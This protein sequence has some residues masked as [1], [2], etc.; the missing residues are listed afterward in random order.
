L[1]GIPK[2]FDFTCLKEN[3][4]IKE[5]KEVVKIK[6]LGSDH[7]C[8]DDQKNCEEKQM[9][10]EQNKIL[11]KEEKEDDHKI[12]EYIKANPLKGV[13]SIKE[14]CK[15][16]K[17]KATHH[18]LKS[19]LYNIRQELFPLDKEM[20]LSK[21]FCLTKGNFGGGINFCRFKGYVRDSK[22]NNNEVMIFSS[23]CLL[24]I[25]KND[26]W[27]VDAT[28]KVAAKGY[29]QL[30]IVIVYHAISRCYLPA[31]FILM[32]H[33][34]N[35]SYKLA[36]SALS[37]ICQEL[38]LNIQPSYIMCDFETAMRN[39]IRSYFPNAKIAG[40]YFH[41]VKALWHYV[42]SNGLTTKEKLHDTIKLVTFLKVLAHIEI[43]DRKELFEE[44][45][46]GFLKAEIKSMWK[47]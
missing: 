28:F 26:C 2:T 17:L 27:F 1:S 8:T 23:P 39:G 16:N 43:P 14:W 34:N 4:D 10:I 13:L 21:P 11:I 40:C 38:G 45:K 44:L 25:L 15:S 42:A 30:L 37:S 22:D 33:K 32:S 12:L 46:G 7:S 9:E 3:E 47:F 18:K 24:K 5:N 41:Y 31:A 6:K 35:L 29:R 36:F 19:M 20:V